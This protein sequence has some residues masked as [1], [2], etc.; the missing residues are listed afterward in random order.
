M[1]M[2]IGICLGLSNTNEALLRSTFH[3]FRSLG[4]DEQQIQEEDS[5]YRSLITVIK[6]TFNA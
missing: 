5:F 1:K 4:Y 3:K 6:S 2:C